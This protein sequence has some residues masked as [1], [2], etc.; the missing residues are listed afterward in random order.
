MHMGPTKTHILKACILR[1][2]KILS[3]KVKKILVITTVLWPSKAHLY[4]TK[5]FSL[6]F[7]LPGKNDI[8][9]KFKMIW[10]INLNL[11][12]LL[13]KQ[14]W[15]KVEKHWSK[16]IWCFENYFRF[17][18]FKYWI[19]ARHNFYLKCIQIWF[20][21]LGMINSISK[22]ILFPQPIHFCIVK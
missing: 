10:V 18:I 1:R 8:Q 22:G 9:F 19:D 2:V 3:W 21:V 5:S 7:I 14:L 12:F 13:R 16:R 20:L 4:L 6:E 17:M 15:K 11:N